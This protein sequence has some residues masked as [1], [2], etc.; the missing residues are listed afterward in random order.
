MEQ[1]S[2]ELENVVIGCLILEQRTAREYVNK[3]KPEYFCDEDNRLIHRAIRDLVT[4]DQ[5]V[6]IFIVAAQLKKAGMKGELHELAY[7]LTSRTEVVASSA[8]MEHYVEQLRHFSLRRKLNS[9]GMRMQRESMDLTLEADGL[10]ELYEGALQSLQA[11]RPWEQV[12]R[13]Q[14]EVAQEAFL[15]REQ[16]LARAGAD[17][18]TGVHTGIPGLDQ[19]T[20][21]WQPNELIVIGGQ[22]GHGKSWFMIHHL[23][24]AAMNGHA[25]LVYSLEM[26]SEDLYARELM[27]RAD[28]SGH[29]W[30][31]K[32]FTPQQKQAV[33]G[34]RQRLD[35]LPI[36]YMDSNEYDIDQLCSM[37]REQHRKGNCD[38]LFIDYAQII[39]ASEKFRYEKRVEVVTD[40]TQKLKNLAKRLHIPVVVLAQLNR[41]QVKNPDGRPQKSDLRESGSL[42]QDADKIFLIWRPY[43][44]GILEYKGRDTRN[45]VIYLEPKDR[46]FG[47]HEFMLFSNEHF[48][49]FSE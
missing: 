19:V 39:R 17:G 43:L 47:E 29:T 38:V 31:L 14:Y 9:L 32:D 26:A 4:Q 6:D 49:S 3:L 8:H 24:A 1:N 21:G 37:A 20:G 25:A 28:I 40:F 48:T 16:A 34:A 18:V 23:L 42:E 2:L 15:Q 30:Y 33:D 41:Q 44:H 35:T 5:E 11:E 36:T 46:K 12:F 22:N 27:S 7:L 45:M 10:V 13:P